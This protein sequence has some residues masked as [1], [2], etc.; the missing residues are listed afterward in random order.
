MSTNNTL[1]VYSD[2]VGG[3]KHIFTEAVETL[4]GGFQVA[5]ANLPAVGN[6]LHAGT[7]VLCNELTRLATVHYAFQ[8]TDVNV[9]TVTIQ[10]KKNSGSTLVK[11]GMFFMVA[12]ATVATTGQGYTV[13]AL[14][15]TNAAY[16]QFV[17]A[18]DLSLTAGDTLVE[19]VAEAADTTV[20][21]VPNA[22]A[23]AD[24]YIGADV[25][26]ASVAGG[27]H[28]KGIVYERRISPICEAVKVELR[29]DTFF[30]YSQ[31]K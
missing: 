3:A 2:Q 27:Y 25:Y 18:G 10:V 22:I 12:P 11:N 4:I 29:K 5:L 15:S 19:C 8:V 23:A 21:V 31:S 20:K 6:A 16:D 9:D 1:T 28:S 24:I 7:P 30:R 26:D 13:S 17:L 14:D